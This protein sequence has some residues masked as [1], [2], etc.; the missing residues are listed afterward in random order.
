MSRESRRNTANENRAVREAKENNEERFEIINKSLV[1]FEHLVEQQITRSSVICEMANAIFTD[2]FKDF[3]GSTFEVSNGGT[4]YLCLWF[5]HNV[6]DDK[7]KYVAFSRFD[8]DGNHSSNKTVERVKNYNRRSRMGDRYRVTKTAREGLEKFMLNHV[9]NL[10]I[11]KS[12]HGKVSVDW[13]VCST[14]VAE[15]QGLINGQQ[16][17]KTL[18]KISYIDVA[19]IFAFRSGDKVTTNIIDKN[20]GEQLISKVDYFVTILGS[21][22]N[23]FGIKEY[24]VDIKQINN[25]VLNS[26]LVDFNLKDYS[27]FGINRSIR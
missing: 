19:S 12:K 24:A 4:P 10:L 6:Y 17:Q 16:A 25:D 11:K 22:I 21:K 1:P 13:D 23:P 3:E 5:N 15:P 14:D 7:N 27:P 20:T 9:D 2:I 8:D 18:S 26:T